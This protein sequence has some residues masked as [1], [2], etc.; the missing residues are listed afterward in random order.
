MTRDSQP[1]WPHPHCS[2]PTSRLDPDWTAGR[3]DFLS[4]SCLGLYTLGSLHWHPGTLVLYTLSE[5]YDACHYC[6]W[7]LHDATN[8]SD[9]CFGDECFV[10]ETDPSIA[11]GFKMK[12]KRCLMILTKNW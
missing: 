3:R 12:E 7:S 4:D 10:I 11:D 8:Q 5:N 6:Y 1:A 9:R 2:R